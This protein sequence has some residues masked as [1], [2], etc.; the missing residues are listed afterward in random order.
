M[1]LATI[2]YGAWPAD[3]RAQGMVKALL[4]A[5]INRLIDVR[6]NPCAANPDPG[7][8]Y[9]PRPWHLQAGGGIA[10]LLAEAGIAYEWF[11]ELG[12]PQ[13]QD[14]SMSVFRSHIADPHGD[15]PVHRGLERL[16]A[17]LRTPGLSVAIL[18]ACGD[19][20]RCHRSEIALALADRIAPE[21]LEVRNIP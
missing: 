16:A 13:R 5:G 12:N 7:A 20:A 2:G 21:P 18:C 1:K 4:G 19:A 3:R 6:L 15:W 8:P 10:E 14:P 9:G 11:A 17:R